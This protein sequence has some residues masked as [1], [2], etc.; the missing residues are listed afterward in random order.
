[1]YCSQELV[2]GFTASN[3]NSALHSFSSV[4]VEYHRFDEEWVQLCYYTGSQNG[5]GIS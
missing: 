1:M 2:F 3:S 4:G 5:D